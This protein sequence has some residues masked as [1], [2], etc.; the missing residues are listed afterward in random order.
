MKLEPIQKIDGG[1]ADFAPYGFNFVCRKKL[2][3]THVCRAEP[4]IL[5]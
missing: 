5:P 4:M 3:A 1:T 2:C